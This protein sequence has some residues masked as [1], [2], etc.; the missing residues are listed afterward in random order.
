VASGLL[1]AHGMRL[2]AASIVLFLS[3]KNLKLMRFRESVMI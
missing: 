1:R 2:A 3:K